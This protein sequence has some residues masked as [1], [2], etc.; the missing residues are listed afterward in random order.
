MNNPLAG[1]GDA[2]KLMQQAQQVQA[3]LQ[4]EEVT[5]ERNGIKVTVRGDQQIMAVE[6]DGIVENRIAD[7]INEAVKQ[8]QQLAATKLKDIMQK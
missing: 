8:T 4:K 3:A 1:L 2:Q 7:A 5:V 6:V